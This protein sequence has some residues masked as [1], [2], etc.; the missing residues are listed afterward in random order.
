MNLM[1]NGADAMDAVGRE[2]RSFVIRS[3]QDGAG[4]I[5]VTVKDVGCGLDPGSI[6]HIFDAFFT[7]KAGGMGM[8]LA[9]CKSIVEAHGG[10]IWAIPNKDRG[11]TFCITL[12][13]NPLPMEGT[14]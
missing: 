8:G 14:S 13:A 2:M 3:T 11:T 5:A 7:S 10:R 4:A 6:D 1:A 12:P 9:I